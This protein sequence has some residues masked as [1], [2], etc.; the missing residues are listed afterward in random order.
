MHIEPNKPT[1]SNEFRPLDEIDKI[2]DASLN[3]INTLNRDHISQFIRKKRN[4]EFP[5][6]AIPKENITNNGTYNHLNATNSW[7][8]K[9]QQPTVV[10]YTKEENFLIPTASSNVK[11]AKKHT[12]NQR[13]STPKALPHFHV[14]YWMFYPYSQGKT[15][16]T[17]N[18]G[19][20]LGKFVVNQ[21]KLQ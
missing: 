2:D 6:D 11:D 19:P 21:L 15:I 16:C 20:L 3:E 18:L 5:F 12:K 7:K 4:S 17:L 9:N 1:V 10:I 14:S 8:H 13:S